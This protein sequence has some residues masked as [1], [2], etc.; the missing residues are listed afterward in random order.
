MEANESCT[1]PIET[2]SDEKMGQTDENLINAAPSF[3]LKHEMNTEL[4]SLCQILSTWPEKR[5]E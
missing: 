1:D 3:R 2:L 5:K 4:L